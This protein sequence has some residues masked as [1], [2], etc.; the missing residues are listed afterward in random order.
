MATT[1]YTPQ[2]RQDLKS[3]AIWIARR[4]MRPSV[5]ATVVRQ[6][7]AVCDQHARN[8]AKG[9]TTGEARPDLGASYRIF[10]Y[11]RWVIIFRP[12]TGGMEVMRIVDGAR[13]FD[14]IFTVSE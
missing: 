2:A 3:I 1:L 14:R 9:L 13:D 11:S 12:I 4:E 6:L 8:F 5:A 7:K 10:S